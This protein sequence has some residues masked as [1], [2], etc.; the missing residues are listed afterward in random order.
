MSFTKEWNHEISGFPVHFP[1][2]LL[3]VNQFVYGKESDGSVAANASVCVY[4]SS[5]HMEHP[6]QTIHYPITLDPAGESYLKQTYL[7]LKSLPEFADA[8]DC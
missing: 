5:E 6:V 2:A 4:P 8:V 3:R 1:S 7:H